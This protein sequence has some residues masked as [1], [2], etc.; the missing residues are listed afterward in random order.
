MK[1]SVTTVH[2]R[3]STGQDL[4]SWLENTELSDWREAASLG[5]EGSTG[6]GK[7]RGRGKGEEGEGRE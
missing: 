5:W 1:L 3:M 6:R 7:G 2:Q 4:S